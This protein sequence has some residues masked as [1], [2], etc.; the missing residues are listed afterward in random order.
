MRDNGERHL[1]IWYTPYGLGGVETYLLNMVRETIR[2][3]AQVWVAATKGANGPLHADFESTGATLLNWSRFHDA[4]M[5]RQPQKRIR[6]Q[7]RADLAAIRPTL[8]ALNDTNDFSM[9]FAPLLRRA[10]P[11]CTI[12]DTFHIDSPADQYMDFRR[13]FLDVLDGI[14]ATNHHVIERF[15]RRYPEREVRVRY[16]AN[17]VSVPD[18]E[19]AAR[20]EALRMLYVGRL[21]HEQKRILELPALLSIL[22][23]RRKNFT[24]TVVGDGPCREALR[25]ELERRGLSERVKLT[26]YLKPE[27]VTKL[28]FEHDVLINLSTFEG[29]SMSVLEAFA[30]GCVPVCTAVTSLDSSVFRD[31]VNC[32]LCP[33]DQLGPMAEKLQQ[34]TPSGIE[35]LST[36]ARKTGTR[37][38]SK[39]TYDEYRTLVR[40]VRG[41]RPI[42][43][44][45][46]DAGAVLSLDWDITAP[47][48]WLT[49]THSLRRIAS[50][51]WKKVKGS[52]S[53]AR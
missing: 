7:V 3:G 37:F 52:L 29:F 8:L 31:G 19:R 50:S 11:Y 48:P 41:S 14:A 2:D 25:V 20:S 33:V 10:R 23:E 28:Y 4:Y 6:E 35:V 36:A 38:T 22:D 45:P 47:N 51:A 43:A 9:G 39:R 44:W 42:G 30:A 16:I 46:D 53:A 15:E 12:I 34:L 26:G 1:W 32:L 27:D 13:S 21:A 49:N 40:E 17:G 24:M 18:R 5:R